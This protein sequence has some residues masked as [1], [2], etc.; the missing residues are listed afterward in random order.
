[1]LVKAVRL[2]VLVTVVLFNSIVADVLLLFLRAMMLPFPRIFTPL[3]LRLM[4]YG[5]A[6]IWRP[7]LHILFQE[8]GMQV[9]Y[10]DEIMSLSKEDAMKSALVMCN[11]VWIADWAFILAAADRVDMLGH[12]RFFV[13]VHSTK[14]DRQLHSLLMYLLCGRNQLRTFHWSDGGCISVAFPCWHATGNGIVP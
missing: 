11:H 14:K 5:A 12:C 6:G 8:S 4:P 7:L 13:K 3:F 1:M 10:S 2:L 9:I